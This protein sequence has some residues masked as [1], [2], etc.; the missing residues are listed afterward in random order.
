MK[1][2]EK[3]SVEQKEKRKRKNERESVKEFHLEEEGGI[4]STFI[5]N[6]KIMKKD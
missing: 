4:M 1:A 3:C 5:Q 2:G 6:W